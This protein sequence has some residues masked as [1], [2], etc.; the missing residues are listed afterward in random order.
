M[1]THVS[2]SVIVLTLVFHCILEARSSRVVDGTKRE[3]GL[4]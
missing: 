3:R 4:T 1:Y 2:F